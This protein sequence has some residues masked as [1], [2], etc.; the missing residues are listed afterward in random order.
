MMDDKVPFM[1]YAAKAF[2]GAAIAGVGT[3]ITAINDGE[4]S[5]VDTLTTVLAVLGVF[6]GIFGTTNAD[7][8]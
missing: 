7:N 8:K 4:W 1:K 5:T 6:G 2:V 3:A